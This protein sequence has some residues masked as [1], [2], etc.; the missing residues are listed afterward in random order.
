MEC[1]GHAQAI[2]MFYT[3]CDLRPVPGSTRSLD[4]SI[5]LLYR[6]TW[7][8]CCSSFCSTGRKLLLFIF[9]P[10]LLYQ[11][12]SASS[13]HSGFSLSLTTKHFVSY[14]FFHRTSSHHQNFHSGYHLLHP[15][16]HLDVYRPD[17]HQREH[18]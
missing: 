18:S 2:H 11:H 16:V 17:I 13:P 5:T 9:S 1:R 12:N 6:H 4:N 15:A 3:D 7:V 8:L 10:K 14:P